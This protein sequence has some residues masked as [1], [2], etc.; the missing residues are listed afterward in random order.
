MFVHRIKLRNLL[1]FGPEGQEL[2][3][4]PLNVL[5][6]PNGAGKSNLVEGIGLLKAVPGKLRQSS[7]PKRRNL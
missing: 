7:I 5:I 6:G 4:K 3:L 1:S 2:E